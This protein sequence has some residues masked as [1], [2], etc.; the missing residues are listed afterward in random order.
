MCNSGMGHG[1]AMDV[2]EL[3]PGK[4]ITVFSIHESLGGM[5]A[6]DGATCTLYFKTTE[7]GTDSN[8]G[9]AEYVGAGDENSASCYCGSCNEHLALCADGTTS[10]TASPGSNFV[11]YWDADEWRET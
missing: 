2:S 6:H 11:I 5:D 9:R 8:R 1:D 3:I 7:P 4:G 10:V